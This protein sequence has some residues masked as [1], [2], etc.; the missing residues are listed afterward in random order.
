MRI[1]LSVSS[2]PSDEAMAARQWW[3]RGEGRGDDIDGRGKRREE[4][5]TASS[6]AVWGRNL[7]STWCEESGLCVKSPFSGTLLDWVFQHWS[8][9]NVTSR[10]KDCLTKRAVGDRAVKKN[11]HK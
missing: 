1:F 9:R 3:R 10:H 5:K 7:A 8:Q 2:L 4:E 6:G 11:A